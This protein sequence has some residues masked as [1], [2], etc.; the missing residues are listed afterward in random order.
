MLPA[1]FRRFAVGAGRFLRELLY[2]Q[3]CCLCGKWANDPEGVPLCPACR[4]DLVPFRG[5]RCCVCGVPLPGSLPALG[6][7]CR[8]CR[9][10]ETP[11]DWIRTLGLYRRPWKDLVRAY[12]FGRRKPLGLFF[13]EGLGV[14]L[15]RELS[16]LDGVVL[17]PI[18]LHP[19]RVRQHGFDPPLELAGYLGKRLHLR[20]ERALIRLRPTP[21]QTGM[22][23]EQRRRNLNGA[24][25][26]R[27]PVSP[28]LE[29]EKVLLVDDVITTG[30]TISTAAHVLRDGGSRW[31]GAVAVAGTPRIFD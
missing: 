5:P 21:P 3:T 31:V 25:G 18:P 22:N 16:V 30:T 14:L 11:C 23:L 24:F 26:L 13:A 9:A 17:V 28:R 7:T 19:R 12:K 8:R 2:P 29:L 1:P 27:S 4:G 20:V 6:G 15:E 10:G